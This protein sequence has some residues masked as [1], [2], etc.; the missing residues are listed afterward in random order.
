MRKFIVSALIALLFCAF[1][2]AEEADT[3]Q[4]VAPAGS[5]QTPAVQA[6]PAASYPAP[7]ALAMPAA[8]NPMSQGANGNGYQPQAAYPAPAYA[9]PFQDAY[10]Q[11][12]QQPN[13][14][15]T[16]PYPNLAPNNSNPAGNTVANV[17][18]Q[19]SPAL[20]FMASQTYYDNHKKEPVLPFILNFILGFGIG[21]FVEGDD[22]GGWIMLGTQLGGVGLMLGGGL[23]STRHGGGMNTGEI[24]MM[25]SG[26]VI[27]VVSRIWG[28][29]RPFT[30]ADRHNKALQ[31]DIAMGKFALVS[32]DA[33]PSFE[34]DKG[35]TGGVTLQARLGF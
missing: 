28:W 20:S 16:M 14:Y 35:F 18:Q 3:S 17:Q 24:V 13:Y 33:F 26:A 5:Y 9:Y 30:Y 6:A 1:A 32:L 29:I 21:S 8:S 4:P 12:Y 19:Q 7:A 25:V 27:T 34:E 2:F 11:G 10:G 22:L 15:G 23:G 31:K